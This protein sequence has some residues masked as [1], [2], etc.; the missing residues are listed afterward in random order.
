MKAQFFNTKKES[1]VV[2]MVKT[3]VLAILVVLPIRYF[4]FQPFFVQ[5]SSMYPNF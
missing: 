2:E 4:I 3:L 1:F 5:G